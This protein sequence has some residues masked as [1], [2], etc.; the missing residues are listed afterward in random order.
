MLFRSRG[1]PFTILLHN[2][3]ADGRY[4]FG[5]LPKA[6]YACLVASMVGRL[7]MSLILYLL[8]ISLEYISIS[9][10]RLLFDLLLITLHSIALKLKCGHTSNMSLLI[11]IFI[12]SNSKNYLTVQICV[13]KLYLNLKY[14]N[15]Q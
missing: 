7:L 13:V 12:I 14:T 8:V 5:S 6:L 11:L 2:A 15:S 4:L 9:A 10:H 1:I 3:S